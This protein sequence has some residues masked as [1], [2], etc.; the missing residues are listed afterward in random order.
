[1][2]KASDGVSNERTDT[3]K[4]GLA[5]EPSSWATIG[6]YAEDQAGEV[7][8]GR[9]PRR[10]AEVASHPMHTHTTPR[11]T[12]ACSDSHY[13]RPGNECRHWMPSCQVDLRYRRYSTWC[14]E[15]GHT[16]VEFVLSTSIWRDVEGARVALEPNIVPYFCEES[17]EHWI[18]WYHPDVTPGSADLD[19][20]MVTK[21]VSHFF[22]PLTLSAVNHIAFQNLPAFRSVPEVAHAHVFLQPRGDLSEKALSELRKE[23]RLRS[24][25][26]EA[27]RLGGRGA[28]VGY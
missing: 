8:A 20:N 28:E 4:R 14:A 3:V 6:A 22:L 11:C 7:A 12:L 26:A 9:G 25:W 15:R 24:P 13:Y 16:G 10:T 23:R 2:A 18:L 19:R 21:L 1:M 27:E 5:T 17:I